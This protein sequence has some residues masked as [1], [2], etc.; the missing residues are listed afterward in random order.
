MKNKFCVFGQVSTHLINL[1]FY[2]WILLNLLFPAFQCLWCDGVNMGWVSHPV[3]CGPK[4]DYFTSDLFRRQHGWL[5]SWPPVIYPP[6]KVQVKW[7]RAFS[8][9]C[10]WRTCSH[11]TNSKTTTK[12]STLGMTGMFGD[13]SKVSS[14]YSQPLC[15]WVLCVLIFGHEDSVTSLKCNFRRRI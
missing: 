6:L 10:A 1:E 3:T 8:A 5:L 15:P 7:R 12:K 4:Q 9:R 2:V 14:I 13:S 11:S